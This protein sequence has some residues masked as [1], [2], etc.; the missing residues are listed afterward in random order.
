[1][2]AIGTRFAE[3]CTGSYGA[4]PPEKLIHIDINADAIGANYPTAIGIHADARSAV[5]ALAEA[6]LA[7]SEPRDRTGVALQIANDKTAYREEWHKHDSGE[8][9]NPGRFFDALRSKLEDDAIV[10]SDDGNHTFLT[11]EL[12][13]INDGGMFLSPTDFNCMGY[14]VPAT[15]ATKLALPER[16]VIGI[17][18]DGAFLMTGLEAVTAASNGIG[19]IWFVF[20]D[21]ELAQIAQAQEAPYQRTTCTAVGALDYEAF[22][23]ATGCG[24]VLLAND[25]DLDEGISNALS[26]AAENKPVVVDVRIDY[27]KKTAFTVGTI[28]TNLQRFDTRT[29]LRIVGRAL[30]RKL[31]GKK[32]D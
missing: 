19:T 20:N 2:L 12:M 4:V 32:G 29:K 23:A 11:A 1:M 31:T 14:C 15:I 25:S 13:T 3:I 24:H 8:R 9:V 22:A 26:L 17:V 18:G 21:G 5:P 28:K 27:S 16:Q 30:Y 10:V 7:G 6:L